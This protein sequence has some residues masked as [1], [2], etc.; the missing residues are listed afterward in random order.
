MSNII[1]ASLS[2]RRYDLLK[3][4]GIDFKVESENI[5]EIMDNSLPLDKRLEDLAYQKALP[6]HLKHPDAIV[7]GADT[8]V[9]FNEQILGK[10]KDYDEAKKMLRMFSNHSQFVYTSVTILHKAQ[11][12]SFTSISEVVFKPLNEQII[13]D[14]LNCNEWQD[15]AGGYAIQGEGKNL[16]DHFVGDYETIVGLPVKQ[17][18]YVLKTEILSK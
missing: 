7:I 5:E 15:K 1:L 8:I 2:P 13:E 6:I 16:V 14:Y 11:R 9:C 18:E 12:I 17:L 4:I 10:P 3:E